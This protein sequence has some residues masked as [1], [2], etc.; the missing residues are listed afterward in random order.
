MYLYKYMIKNLRNILAVLYL[1]LM[2]QHTNLFAQIKPIS[3]HYNYLKE[4]HNPAFY[5]VDKQYKFAANYRTQ[6][7]KLSG[8]PQTIN[9]LSSFHFPKINSG[10]G[11][12]VSYDKVG[13]LSI[14]TLQTGYNYIIPIKN[15]LSIGIGAQV[16]FEFNNLDGSKLIT[17]EGNYNSGINHNDDVLNQA[18]VKSFRPLMNFGISINSKY[19]NAGIAYLNTI[20]NRL[21]LDGQNT[22]LITK[23]GSVLQVNLNSNIKL[24]KD[25]VLI[26][27]FIIQSDFV[28]VQTDAQLLLGYKYFGEL[29]V[30]IRGHNKKSLESVSPIIKIT[31]MK[32]IGLGFIYSYDVNLN[33]LSQVN[34]NTHEITIFYNMNSKNIFKQPKFINN[35]RFL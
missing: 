9:I 31:P 15:K 14:T 32:N 21:K 22:N 23:Y 5:G 27:A 30:N 19:I 35:P 25:F 4:W 24:P 3:T 16:G 1:L 29:G 28:N 34:K 26:P 6:W 7:T 8:A 20:N 2:S 18:I 11:I 17:P 33:G 13:A 12:N 10:V